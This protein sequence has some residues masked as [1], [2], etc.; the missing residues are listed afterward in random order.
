MIEQPNILLI[1]TDQQNST[2]MSCAGNAYV[3][4]PAMDSLA[5]EGVRFERAYCTNPVCVPSRFSLMTGLMPSA[6]GMLSNR[7]AHID[8]IPRSI[9]GNGLGFRLREAGYDVAYA[10]KVHLPKMSAEDVGFD[11]ICQDERERLAKS[12]AEF[13]EKSRRRPFCLVASFINPHDICYMAIRDFLQTASEK[14]LV[15]R[16][17]VE[18]ATLDAALARPGAVDDVTFFAEHCPPLP[19]NFEP[20]ADEPEAIRIMLEQRPFRM[21]ARR[22]WDENRWREHRWAYAR[23]TEMVDKQIARVLDALSRSGQAN[24]TLVVF[25]SDHG[26]MDSSHRM[27]H[28]STLYDEACRIPLI[29]RPPGD[30]SPGRVDCTHLVS[31]GLDLLPT[32]C[33][34]AG[35]APPSRLPGRSLRRLV[36]GNSQECRRR[37]VPVECAIGRAI[38]TERFKYSVYDIGADREQLIDLVSDPHE[39]RNVLNDSRYHQVLEELRAVFQRTFGSEP[40]HPADVVKAAADA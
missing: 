32:F 21:K 11:Y 2:M 39:Q 8:G 13:I 26:D 4:T 3:S 27:E 24:R 16:G 29:I 18:C 38:V 22:E 31:N 7:V 14:R 28:K 36:E 19:P 33:D 9:S 5:A 6:I 20:P 34:Y 40:R 35:V 17:S 1:L 15:E 10:G 30:G 37:S 25:T 23:L 12:C